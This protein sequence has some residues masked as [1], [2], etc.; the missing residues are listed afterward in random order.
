MEENVQIYKIYRKKYFGLLC[1]LAF[2][3]FCLHFPLTKWK[4]KKDKVTNFIEQIW[5][6][7]CVWVFFLY[8]I[9]SLMNLLLASM[10]CLLVVFSL[11]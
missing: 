11:K 7:L 1:A 9:I 6:N 8:F 3:I 2:W 5:L 10:F 4:T